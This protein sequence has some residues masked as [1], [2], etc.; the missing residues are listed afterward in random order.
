[1]KSKKIMQQ[2]NQ[3]DF[4]IPSGKK[5]KIVHC[6]DKGLILKHANNFN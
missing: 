1:M 4:L 6:K 5:K 2:T 3:Y